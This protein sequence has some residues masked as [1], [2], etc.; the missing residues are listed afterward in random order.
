V[1]EDEPWLGVP[2]SFATMIRSFDVYVTR[3]IH[4]PLPLFD[5]RFNGEQ[6]FPIEREQLACRQGGDGKGWKYAA[7]RDRKGGFSLNGKLAR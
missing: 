1:V 2:A 4:H 5:Y 7:W 6:S 3:L